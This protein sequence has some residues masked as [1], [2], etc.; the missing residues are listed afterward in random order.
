MA[1]NKK[2]G[3]IGLVF[4]LVISYWGPW[5]IETGLLDKSWASANE[6]T[7]DDTICFKDFDWP[8][9]L[10]LVSTCFVSSLEPPY[11]HLTTFYLVVPLR[12]GTAPNT[13]F[14]SPRDI[15]NVLDCCNSTLRCCWP[16]TGVVLE[17]TWAL[18]TISPFSDITN[19]DPLDRGI[20][21]PN[22][23][24]LREQHKHVG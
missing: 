6:R 10:T 11:I 3:P 12:N 9:P 2:I 16:D 18:V 20:V 8:W 4:A 21:R 7:W 23:G 1:K 14:L 22:R 5:E 17:T 24:C 15:R 19:P 13:H